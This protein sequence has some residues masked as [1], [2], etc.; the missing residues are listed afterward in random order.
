LSSGERRKGGETGNT[1]SAK[2]QI[3]ARAGEER[4]IMTRT[5]RKSQICVGKLPPTSPS[6]PERPVPEGQDKKARKLGGISQ[7]RKRE[8]IKSIGVTEG[9]GKTTSYRRDASGG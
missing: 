4:L 5:N 2:Q 9:A 7:M 3:I 6:P 1:A 8:E